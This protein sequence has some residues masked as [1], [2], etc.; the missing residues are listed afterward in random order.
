MPSFLQ[1]LAQDRTATAALVNRRTG[2]IVADQLIPALDS[3]TRRRGLLHHDS[4]PDGSAMII[5]PSSAVHTF[6]MK[7]AIDVAFVGRDGRIRKIREAV[8]PWRIAGSLGSYAVVE[9]PA[10]AL[11]RAGTRVGDQLAVELAGR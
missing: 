3:A 2:T 5:A 8:A 6:F 11:R 1:P 7:F 10:G 9:L 4:L